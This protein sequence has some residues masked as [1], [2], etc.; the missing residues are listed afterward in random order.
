MRNKTFPAG[1]DVFTGFPGAR[2]YARG[3][4]WISYLAERRGVPCLIVDT[5]PLLG[6]GTAA[7]EIT[8]ISFESE[9]ERAIYLAGAHA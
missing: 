5:R 7:G 8:V 6:D 2:V 9:H 3:Q 4:G 1:R